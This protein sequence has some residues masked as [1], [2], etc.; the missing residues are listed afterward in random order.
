MKITTAFLLCAARLWLSSMPCVAADA[1]PPAQKSCD[2]GQ[3]A[4]L[5]MF[6]Q[7]DGSIAVPAS[8]NGRD[9]RLV[10]DTGDIYSGIAEEAADAPQLKRRL[11]GEMF[12]FLGNVP[13]YEYVEPESFTLGPLSAAHRRFMVLPPQMTSPSTDGLLGPD[14]LQVFDVEFDFAHAK[15]NLFSPDHC[16]NMVVYWTKGGYAQIPM[17]VDNNFHVTVSVMLNGKPL[18][19]AVDTGADRTTMSLKT[20]Q[21]V[22]G[23][24]EKNAALKAIGA[25]SIN[26]T[27]P[28]QI[29]RYPFDTLSLEG[30]SV[31]NPDIDIVP[32]RI[33]GEKAPQIIIGINVLR[34][35]RLY[36]AYKEQMLYV[37]PAEAQ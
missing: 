1:P 4:S 8:F 28:T 6:V 23:I 24:D 30:V 26:G 13:V 25:R 20:V 19:A 27:A 9:A 10:V 17:H 12:V 18:T 37:T 33:Y 3:I 14:I 2:L 34:Q 29:Y 32:E 5:D 21:E 22:F 7:P 31:Q 36:I 11:A 35:L 16:P 15:F